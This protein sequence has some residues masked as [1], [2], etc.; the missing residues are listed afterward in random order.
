MDQSHAAPTTGKLYLAAIIPT[1][2]K[3][4]EYSLTLSVSLYGASVY[5][6]ALPPTRSRQNTELNRIDS[7]RIDSTILLWQSLLCALQS[8]WSFTAITTKPTFHSP[9]LS[10]TYTHTYRLAY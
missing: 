1:A 5:R 7:N 10:H 3:H 4:R 8:I 6:V 9:S 2:D